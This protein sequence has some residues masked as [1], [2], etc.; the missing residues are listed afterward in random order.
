MG[1][2]AEGYLYSDPNGSMYKMG[3]LA[4]TLVNHMAASENPIL[5]KQTT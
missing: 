2:L 4:E 3:I 5:E 1:T